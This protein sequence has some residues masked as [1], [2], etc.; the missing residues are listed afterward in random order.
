MTR[1][2]ELFAAG[3]PVVSG[4]VLVADAVTPAE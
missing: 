1:Q 4:L 3:D 2:G